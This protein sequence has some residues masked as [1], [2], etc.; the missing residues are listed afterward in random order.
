MLILCFLL[1]QPVYKK[2]EM[3][4]D[5]VTTLRGNSGIIQYKN[6]AILKSISNKI[7]HDNIIK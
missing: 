6:F 3:S 2:S 1:Q 7:D 5:N 4:Y